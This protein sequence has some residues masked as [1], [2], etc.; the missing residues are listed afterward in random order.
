MRKMRKKFSGQSISEYVIL[1]GIV[2]MALFGMQVYMKRGIQGTIKSFS[3]GIG[4]QAKGA[5]EEDSQNIW[6]ERTSQTTSQSSQN[7]ATTQLNA[8]AV[9]YSTT[10][11][12]VTTQEGSL[13]KGLSYEKE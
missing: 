5:A 6:L 4:S 11:P 10:Q 13:Y 12:E 1:V 9:R 3:D 8:G 7:R 2:S